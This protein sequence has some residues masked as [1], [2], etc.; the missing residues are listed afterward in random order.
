MN[1]EVL[2]SKGLFLFPYFSDSSRIHNDIDVW[3]LPRYRRLS[4][5]L[6]LRKLVDFPKDYLYKTV[7]YNVHQH[8]NDS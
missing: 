4:R 6:S 1:N 7:L 8:S 3:I 5:D 2:T